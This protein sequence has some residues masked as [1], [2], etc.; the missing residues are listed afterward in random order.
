MALDPFYPDIISYRVKI[1][2]IKYEKFSG[3][4]WTACVLFAPGRG[5]IPLKEAET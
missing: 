5:I 1:K 3:S 4:N 2:Y